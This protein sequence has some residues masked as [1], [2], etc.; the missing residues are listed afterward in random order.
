MK[1]QLRLTARSKIG[2]F[3]PRWEGRKSLKMPIKLGDSKDLC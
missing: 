3:R 1:R 2:G